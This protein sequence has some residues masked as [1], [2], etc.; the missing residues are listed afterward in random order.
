MFISPAA[1]VLLPFLPLLSLAAPV[2]DHLAPI[3]RAADVGGKNA[4]GGHIV[5]FKADTVDPNNRLQWLNNILAAQG[6]TLDNATIQSL[7]LQWS[8]DVFNGLAGP[9]PDEALDVLRK[10]PEVAYIEEGSSLS[11]VGVVIVS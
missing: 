5:S 3:R 7:K 8:K 11:R 9:L 2:L 4:N 10:R 6:I 1:L